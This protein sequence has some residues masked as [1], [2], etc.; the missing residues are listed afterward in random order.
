MMLSPASASPQ[1]KRAAGSPGFASPLRT[2]PTERAVRIAREGLE[3]AE[4]LSARNLH[5]EA[6]QLTASSLEA[7][8]AVYAKEQGRPRAS[9]RAPLREMPSPNEQTSALA[10]STPKK[11]LSPPKNV[12]WQHAPAGNDI[13]AVIISGAPLVR[14]ALPEDD[15]QPFTLYQL[16]VPLTHREHLIF[17]R[18]SHFVA[19]D[20]T[21]RR[22]LREQQLRQAADQGPP[23]AA[24]G[25]L[26]NLW[27][28]CMALRHLPAL[29]PKTLPLVQDA[30]HPT[31]VSQRWAGLQR[32]LDAAL[33]RVI[34]CP[35]ALDALKEFLDL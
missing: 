11:R 6:A 9:L 32:Y 14:H 26:G 4:A 24:V 2:P 5:T 20:S 34:D 19:L 31:I 13:K 1:L 30:T 18:Y 12:R 22:V 3:A 28:G 33:E 17:R 21:L 35:E 15:S 10:P 23:A 25:A 16:H 27:G 29:P 7:A 8:A